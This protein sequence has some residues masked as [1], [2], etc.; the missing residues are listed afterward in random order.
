MGNPHRQ[1]R[2]T[3]VGIVHGTSGDPVAVLCDA[4]GDPPGQRWFTVVLSDAPPVPDEDEGPVCVDCLLDTHPRLSE[5][6]EIAL[7][8]NGA[9]WD[10]EAWKPAPELWDS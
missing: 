1:H 5:G 7:E 3:T 8:H 10:G 4:A 2:R 9:E 6:L